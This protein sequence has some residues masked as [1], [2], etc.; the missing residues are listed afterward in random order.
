MRVCLYMTECLYFLR[1]VAYFPNKKKTKFEPAQILHTNLS[2]FVN[3]AWSMV[4]K[5]VD[6]SRK[7]RAVTSPLSILIMISLCTFSRADSV[8]WCFLQADCN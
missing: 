2:L 1:I 4:S 3:V 6:K 7:V 8:E 5:A